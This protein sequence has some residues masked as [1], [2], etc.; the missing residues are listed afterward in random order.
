M[1]GAAALNSRTREADTGGSLELKVIVGYR[2]SLRSAWTTS[3]FLE[4]ELKNVKFQ[5]LLVCKHRSIP[6]S[7]DSSK[8]A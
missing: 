2:V 4:C 7:R 8:E 3:H 6:S 5:D 1:C